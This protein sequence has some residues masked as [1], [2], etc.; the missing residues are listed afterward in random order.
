MVPRTVVS[1]AFE[2]NPLSQVQ[3]RL[4]VPLSN[5][6]PFP[7]PPQPRPRRLP[8]PM[9]VSNDARVL[10]SL[11]AFERPFASYNA[12]PTLPVI[13]ESFSPFLEQLPKIPNF[14]PPS[15][16]NG[17]SSIH[18]H[19]SAEQISSPR[20]G[21]G[22]PLGVPPA[23]DSPNTTG[24]QVHPQDEQSGV[25]WQAQFP[26]QRHPSGKMRS[27]N[28]VT[29]M[30]V[31]GQIQS[32]RPPH[33]YNYPLPQPIYYGP[34][35][36]RNQLQNYPMPA[37]LPTLGSQRKQS[38]GSQSGQVG[39]KPGNKDRRGSATSG[40]VRQI[41]QHRDRESSFS[42]DRPPLQADKLWVGNLSERDPVEALVN[43]FAPL[44][45]YRI[46]PLRKS[47]K[48]SSPFRWFT[49]I[50]SGILHCFLLSY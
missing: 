49:F 34:Q 25:P 1:R 43:M 10:E 21:S 41:P 16:N 38:G 46:S 18:R 15:P 12:T 44:G 19:P 47:L 27:S 11:E 30:P 3:T 32:Y 8:A 50:R 40:E 6:V 14:R 29:P 39:Q 48:S 26:P 22:Q 35:V 13:P 5:R 2:G 17:R 4:A 28:A 20:L 9:A 42:G 45:A 33:A 23:K 36:Q 37:G 24:F 7:V 31:S